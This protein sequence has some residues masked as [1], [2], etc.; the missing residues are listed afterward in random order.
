MIALLSAGIFLTWIRIGLLC[1]ATIS[2]SS[3]VHQLCCINPLPYRLESWKEGFDKDIPLGLSV[4]WSLVVCT[5]STCLSQCW[6]SGLNL[7]NSFECCHSSSEFI[8]PL[9]LLFFLG[10]HRFQRSSITSNSYNIFTPLLHRSEPWEA[11]S[12][13]ACKV[14]EQLL[15]ATT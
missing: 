6:S 12:I 9:I 10:R 1:V 14:L 3:W 7:Y 5:L 4:P 8:C 13:A 11:E 15:N 2:V